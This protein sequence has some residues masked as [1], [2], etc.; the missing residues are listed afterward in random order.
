MFVDDPLMVPTQYI[1]NVQ[2]H[3][4]VINNINYDTQVNEEYMSEPRTHLNESNCEDRM[5][6]KGLKKK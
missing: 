3:Y 4:I 1:D 2:R 5:T 6:K